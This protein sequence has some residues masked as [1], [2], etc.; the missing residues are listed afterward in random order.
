MA[1]WSSEPLRSIGRTG[2]NN[3]RHEAQVFR[4]KYAHLFM[5]EFII[6]WQWKRIS[7][8]QEPSDGDLATDFMLQENIDGDL[9][10]Y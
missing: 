4:D 5:N 1:Y 10:E 2:S 7:L 9:E 6:P 3:Y 8:Y